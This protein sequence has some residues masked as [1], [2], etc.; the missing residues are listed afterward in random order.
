MLESKVVDLKVCSFIKKETPMQVFSSEI[1]EV[2]KSIFFYRTPP[3]AASVV[4]AAK[5]LIIFSVITINVGYNQKLSSK[6]CN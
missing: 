5:Q 6:Y 3:V 2:F 1:G 4:F